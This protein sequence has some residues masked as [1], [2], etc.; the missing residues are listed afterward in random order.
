M[1][2]N[3]AVR[4]VCLFILAA[5]LV[6]VSP[7]LAD[8]IGVVHGELVCEQCSSYAGLVIDITDSTRQAASTTAVASNGSFEVQ[9]VREGAYQLSVRNL[10][11]EVI[12]QDIVQ[13]SRHAPLQIT[14]PERK[15]ER[16]GSGT[17]SIG[18]LAH[19]VPKQAKKEYDKAGG[20]LKAGDV[21]GSLQHL[22]KAV[23]IDPE[24]MEAH[25]NLGSR[26]LM[27]QEYD[28]A[29]SA[30]RR[31]LELD[32]SAAMVQLNLAVALMSTSK[33]KEAEGIARRVLHRNPSDVKAN[34]VVGLALY[35]RRQ[36]T[37]ETVALLT[38]SQDAFPNARLAV[39]AIHAIRGDEMKA[40]TELEVYIASPNA[41]KRNEAKTMLAQLGKGN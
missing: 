1:W 4:Y 19:K 32:P 3:P 26:Y 2:R 41:T 15:V 9:N 31:A 33:V 38:K 39:A 20:K 24:Y 23:E 10:Q 6:T 21:R 12:H 34:Y 17:V 28:L 11:G 30:F 5:S 36:F 40:K 29:I 27:L 16:P 25:N 13:I 14:V 8:N 22:L 7:V 37:D 35:S 18:R